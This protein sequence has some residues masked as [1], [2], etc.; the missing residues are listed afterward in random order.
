MRK[1]IIV[2]AG[3]VVAAAGSAQAQTRAPALEN[4]ETCLRERVAEAV[5]AGSGAADAAEFLLSYLCAEAV[6]TSGR[7]RY[8]SGMVAAMQGVTGMFGAVPDDGAEEAEDD[9]AAE[10]AGFF[11]NMGSLSVDQITGEIVGAEGASAMLGA[12][13]AQN[14]F[15]EALYLQPSADLRALAGQLI[16]DARRP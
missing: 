9:G 16:L 7:Y 11:G 14:L 4:A 3:L 8:N 10:T 1:M 13:G 12:M 15:M 5:A 6:T 2:L